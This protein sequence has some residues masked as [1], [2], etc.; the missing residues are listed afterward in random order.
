MITMCDIE[1]QALE[2][3]NAGIVIVDPDKRVVFWNN[4]IRRL[5]GITKESALGKNFCD[6]CPRFSESRYRD[7]L[8]NLFSTGQSRFCSGIL[9]KAFI[10]PVGDDGCGM[11]QNL[12]ADPISSGGKT[13]FALLQITDITE[14]IQNKINLEKKIED[15]KKGYQKIKESEEC[16]QKEA[17]YDN[18]T[19]ILSRY[20]LEIEI[21]GLIKSAAE[22]QRKLAVLFMDIDG[23]KNVN[24]TYGH[25]VGDVLLQQVAGRVKNNTRQNKGRTKDLIIRFGGDEF[26]IILSNIKD[27]KD[28]AFVSDKIISAINRPFKIDNNTIMVSASLGISVYP[29]DS[30]DIKTLINYADKAMYRNK[31]VEK[32]KFD[33]YNKSM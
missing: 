27:T 32:G 16:A 11:Y 7:I 25:L 18:L 29:D 2:K 33:F 28:A 19:G 26:V 23:F 4:G 9:H 20:G 31:K 6:I 10:I 30:E 5:S 15:L 17:Y 13:E 3:I 12:S 24:D 8:D 1:K 21:P 14:S 22:A